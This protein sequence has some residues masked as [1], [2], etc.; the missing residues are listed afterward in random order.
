MNPRTILFQPQN[1]VGLGH[2][3][4]LAAIAWAARQ[5]DP[6]LR[7]PFVVE[8]AA[9]IFLDALGLPYLPI[10]SSH[11]L[12]ETTDWSQWPRQER[13]NLQAD[14]SN[15]ILQNT[16]PQ[17]VVFDCFPNEAFATV[18]VEKKLP[19]VL[20]LRETRHL[21][22]QLQRLS[23]ILS[24]VVLILIPHK[25]G[26]FELPGNLRERSRFVGT[27]IRPN[28]PK[29]FRT[30]EAGLFEIVISGGGGGHADTATFFN[31]AMRA[32]SCMRDAGIQLSARL[33]TGPLF[34]D[35]ARL[36]LVKDV[37]VI[38][39][40]AALMN[41]LDSADL[42]ICQAGYNT[43]VELECVTARAMIL[44]GERRWDDQFDRAER[45]AKENSRIRIF[46]GSTASELA[47][48]A[49]E[50]LNQPI[51]VMQKNVPDGARQAAEAI[52]EWMK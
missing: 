22:H 32:V 45:A 29:A 31:L 43:M 39:F 35:W 34:A 52:L 51:S 2:M 36:E 9:H 16:R 42:V 13:C 14:I 8:G 11:L 26:A 17:I 18:V 41:T 30:K 44:P 10:P 48:Q 46:S 6:S 28:V 5:I 47:G 24:H 19:I 25:E 33:I 12:Y 40:D 20:C 3:N 21:E 37:I 23:G 27:M 1:H 7:T 49:M 38:P 15:S 50:W 4:R